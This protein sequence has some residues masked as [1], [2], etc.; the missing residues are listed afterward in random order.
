M[1]TSMMNTSVDPCQDFYQ[2]ANGA[3]LANTTLPP[4]KASIERSISEISEHNNQLL[5]EIM[6][7]PNNTLLYGISQRCQDMDRRNKIGAQ[8]L[9]AQ[10]TQV[11]GESGN[12]KAF[13]RLAAVATRRGASPLFSFYAAP[14]PKVP[15][16]NVAT[17]SQGGF[18]L[19]VASL[20][21]DPNAQHLQ[22]A[23]QKYMNAMFVAFGFTTND[24]RD[25][26]QAA[27]T[28]ESAIAKHALDPAQF[29]DPFSLYNPLNKTGLLSLCQLPLSSYFD[30]AMGRMPF[31]FVVDVP[32]FY[33]G[34]GQALIHA[35]PLERSA[36]LVFHILD[37]AAPFLSQDFLDAH[38]QFYGKTLAGQDEP[39]PLW[40]QCGNAAVTLYPTH[41]GVAFSDLAFPQSEKVT[42]TT[43]VQQIQTQLKNDIAT[44]SWMSNATKQQATKKID[45]LLNVIG[46]SDNPDLSSAQLGQV[47]IDSALAAQQR[48]FSKMVET[49]DKK[50]N[51]LEPEMS[52]FIV[53]AF[54]DPTRNS[55]N[56]LAGISQSPY[57]NP[58]F[59]VEMNSAGIGVIAGHETSHSLDS[60]GSEYTGTGRLE[61]WWTPADLK[62]FNDR[63][64]CI[65]EQ[66]NK[67]E[68]VPG[69]HVNGNLTK[70]EAVA[71]TGGV[72]FSYKAFVELVGGSAEAAKQSTVVK[73][74]TRAQLFFTA[75]C[76]GWAAV[77][78]EQIAVRLASTDP[79]P[80]PK[81][82]CIGP[83]QDS[84]FFAKAFN[85]PANTYMNPSKKCDVW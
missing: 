15:N 3:W 75:Y 54:Y 2:Y 42:L 1:V 23:L 44:L 56:L 67:F 83:L 81:A 61:N 29:G 49:I 85:C 10:I 48:L 45:L 9:Q 51:K 52:N 14:D 77:Q 69:V 59:P 76:Q 43:M 20:Y 80:P 84:E 13:L 24:A 22:H 6:A 82:R 58:N 4:D 11:L 33:A 5:K 40:L 60:D 31:D 72:K 70:G 71:D 79:H 16:I 46:P 35:S 73:S 36:Y 30:E 12:L 25:L 19:P 37:G 74:L 7:S 47:F 17:L 66:Y 53:N 57:F 8:P 55:L 50:V 32:S 62:E 78:S 34:L 21:S 26:M 65:I 41:V 28:L 64:D 68:V 38:F 18:T 27:Y 39:S 63:V